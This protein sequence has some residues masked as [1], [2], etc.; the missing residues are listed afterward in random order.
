M[1]SHFSFIRFLHSMLRTKALRE[2]T[3][4]LRN[5]AIEVVVF[6][7]QKVKARRGYVVYF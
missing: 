1:H 2:N 3:W 5:E 6:H 4:S 7:A